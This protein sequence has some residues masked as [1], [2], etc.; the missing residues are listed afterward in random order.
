LLG[1]CD[2]F[3]PMNIDLGATKRSYDELIRNYET[4]AE[5]RS[6]SANND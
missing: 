4:E 6:T 1:R 3:I 5:Q 2:A